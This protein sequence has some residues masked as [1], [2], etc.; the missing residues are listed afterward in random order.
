MVKASFGEC[1]LPA[2]KSDVCKHGVHLHLRAASRNSSLASTL[3]WLYFGFHPAVCRSNLC[4]N[5]VDQ[6]ETMSPSETSAT[7]CCLPCPAQPSHLCVVTAWCSKQA[8]FAAVL[9]YKPGFCGA[10]NA[11]ALPG[12]WPRCLCKEGSTQGGTN[13]RNTERF[14]LEGTSKVI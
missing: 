5:L 13:Q 6:G 14:G 10:R 9:S 2:S 4:Q 8:E 11:Q 12:E 1:M 7:L 3:Q